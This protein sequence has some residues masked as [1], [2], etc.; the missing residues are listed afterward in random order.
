MPPSHHFSA[1]RPSYPFNSYLDNTQDQDLE[2]LN[3]LADVVGQE[4]ETQARPF[5]TIALDL[6]I[7]NPVE[8]EWR[9]L[10][11]PPTSIPLSAQFKSNVWRE[12]RDANDGVAPDHLQYTQTLYDRMHF[13]IER[14]HRL[15]VA[16]CTIATKISHSDLHSRLSL[17]SRNKPSKFIRP[18]QAV[19][20]QIE[21]QHVDPRYKEYVERR[22]RYRM[23]ATHPN[24]NK[25][26]N[27]LLV[28]VA[29]FA[30]HQS[31]QD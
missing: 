10:S 15:G 18:I 4:I 17:D 23:S 2:L 14:R 13:M 21:R 8:L 29:A 27:S 19:Q 6:A 30:I 24:R 1:P 3:G 7:E 28:A 20:R 5:A 16:T 9:M 12:L 25:A 31:R 22:A 11:H 26:R